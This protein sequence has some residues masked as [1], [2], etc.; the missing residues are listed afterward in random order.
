[1]R[2]SGTSKGSGICI[3]GGGQGDLSSLSGERLTQYEARLPSR[4]DIAL[5]PVVTREYTNKGLRA[6]YRQAHARLVARVIHYNVGWAWDHL[7]APKGR[8]LPDTDEMK[9]CRVAWLEHDMFFKTVLRGPKRGQKEGQAFALARGMLERWEQGEHVDRIC[10]GKSHG[11]KV[12]K[13]D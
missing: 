11:E 4:E 1:M 9:R 10:G 5:A 3:G 12:P 2:K 13:C 8:G 7:P 6:R